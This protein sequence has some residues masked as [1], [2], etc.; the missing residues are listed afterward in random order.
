M[1]IKI[2]SY[3][4][5]VPPLCIN[6]IAYDECRRRD[7]AVRSFSCA[8]DVMSVAWLIGD[9]QYGVAVPD[10]FLLVGDREIT[11]ATIHLC[12]GS[13][14]VP[15]AFL[16]YEVYQTRVLTTGTSTPSTELSF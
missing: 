2:P 6:G 15:A 8:N 11:T 14:K 10:A 9:E 13:P 12:T 1:T 7:G 5:T 16:C 4:Y 3:T